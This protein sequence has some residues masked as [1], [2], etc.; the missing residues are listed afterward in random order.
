[1]TVPRSNA[2][3]PNEAPASPAE[4]FPLA[5]GPLSIWP[6]AI[7]APMAG[8]TSYPFRALCNRFGAGLCVNEM[9]TARPLVDRSRRSLQ[10]AAF[11]PDEPIRSQQLY[12]VDPFHV[13][14]A[15]RL[16]VSETRIDHLDLNFGCPVR[17]VTRKG[18]GAAIP[19]K[20]RL[21]RDIVRAAVDNAG[22]IP[23]TVKFRLGID[24]DHPTFIDSAGVARDE[25][26]AAVCLHART[27]RQL[28]SGR[29]RW[30]EI[31]HLKSVF[32]D[33]AVLGNGDIWEARDAMRM[34]RE[35]GC[36]GVVIGRGCLGRPWLFRDIAALF[37][38]RNPPA[39]P[40]LGEV[41]D[42]M[43]DHARALAEWMGEGPA[44]RAFR[45]HAS[46]YTK[47]FRDSAALRRRLMRIDTLD[48]L[49][50][51]VAPLDRSEPFPSKVLRV[52]RG[53]SGGP[54]KVVLPDGY[55]EDPDD[56]TPPPESAEDPVSGG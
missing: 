23:V 14:E 15:V 13:G 27:A 5:L 20:P 18:G 17:K 34:M 45:R 48:A 31:A 52:P 36:D 12:G 41:I 26:C 47:G 46:W 16:L 33:L 51:A 28:Y 56:A 30:R 1:L 8:V 35:T 10:L 37:E 25:G 42:I 29:A 55:L 22:A 9:V 2:S 19:L 21:L 7:L 24:D 44:L 3:D 40:L 50:K 6:P 38:G 32:P 53:K 39:L 11:G 4:F 54:Q 49:E 43:L